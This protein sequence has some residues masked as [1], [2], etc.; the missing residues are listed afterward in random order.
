MDWIELILVKKNNSKGKILTVPGGKNVTLNELQQM[1]C[2]L[3]L[4]DYLQVLVFPR[5]SQMQAA[6]E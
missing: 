5:L 4:V 2:A 1:C 3:I 6:S